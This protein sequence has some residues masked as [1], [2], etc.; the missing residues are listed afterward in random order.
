MDDTSKVLVMR[1]L[2]KA[3]PRA[4]LNSFRTGPNIDPAKLRSKSFHEVLQTVATHANNNPQLWPNEP[5]HIRS[6]HNIN[7]TSL[8]PTNPPPNRP[9]DYNRQNRPRPTTPPNTTTNRNTYRQN[10]AFPTDPN[11]FCQNHNMWGHST[12]QCRQGIPYC[13]F[14]KSHGHTTQDCR[15]AS[16]FPRD[17]NGYCTNH[18]MP[19]HT[20]E[21]CRNPPTQNRPRTPNTQTTNR[22][23]SNSR[24]RTQYTTDT[25]S[26]PGYNTYSDSTRYGTRGGYS[27]RG[28]NRGGRTY[29]NSRQNTPQPLMSINTQDPPQTSHNPQ[30]VHDRDHLNDSAH[31]SGLGIIATQQS[32]Y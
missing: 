26:N 23:R 12:Q 20:T 27:R 7:T 18:Q 15:I 9:N 25:Q 32:T 14:H 13:R 1:G 8:P 3:V 4:A 6:F 28:Y 19:G 24:D 11:A 29:T 5:T 2:E 10:P 21:Q 16:P 31:T 22:S 30:P 17:P